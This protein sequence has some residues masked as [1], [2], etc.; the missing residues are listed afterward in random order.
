MCAK[1]VE[2]FGVD[3]VMFGTDYGP[4][5]IDPKEH[6]D[7]VNGL[8]ISAADKEKILWRNA[9]RF[10]NCLSWPDHRACRSKPV[11]QSITRLAALITAAHFSTSPGSMAATSVGVL[12]AAG[13][14]CLAIAART[15]S[16]DSAVAM[17]R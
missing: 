10:S 5:P 11:T 17:V 9:G 6:I 12:S 8:A 15:E 14:P 2:V 13:M 3:R 7:I 1:A 4:V 16:F